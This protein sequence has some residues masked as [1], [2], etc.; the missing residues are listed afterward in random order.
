MKWMWITDIIQ[1]AAF[2]W[3]NAMATWYFYLGNMKMSEGI[4]GHVSW[5]LCIT[6]AAAS[7]I[8][9]LASFAQTFVT[10]DEELVPSFL[11]LFF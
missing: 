6:L 5:I 7:V 9:G 10:D 2:F 4:H 3:F 1:S 8:T 11:R